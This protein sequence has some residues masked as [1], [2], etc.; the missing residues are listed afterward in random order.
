M[1]D[2]VIA[3]TAAGG[4]IHAEFSAVVTVTN[5]SFSDNTVSGNYST[6]GGALNLDL[7]TEATINGSSFADNQAI[8][9]ASSPTEGDAA[10]GGRDQ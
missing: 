9:P 8:V 5:S 7:A 4:A 10:G 6:Q 3:D 1:G 2:S